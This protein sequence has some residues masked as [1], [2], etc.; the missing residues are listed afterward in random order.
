MLET[1]GVNL[2]IIDIPELAQRNIAALLPED[3]HGVATLS[4]D[5]QGGLITLTRQGVLYL[6]R[7]LATSARQLADASVQG[8]HFEQVVL[9]VQRSLDYYEGHFRLPPIAHVAIAPLPDDATAF[10]RFLGGNLNAKVRLIDLA[11][12]IDVEGESP[13]ALQSGCLAALGAA[14][15]QEV[16]AL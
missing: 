11:E 4:F 9:E 12:L 7:A 5:D 15:R 13:L 1:A 6:S 10:V 2:D 14:L 3:V 8:A 16:K